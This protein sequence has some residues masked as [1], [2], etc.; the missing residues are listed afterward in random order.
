METFRLFE[1]GSFG[2]KLG[3]KPLG[4]VL[5]NDDTLHYLKACDINNL[6][7]LTAFS[8]LNEFIDDRGQRVKINYSSLDVEEFGSVYEG[9]LE[10][11]P[12]V[13]PGISESE[14]RFG[15][16]DGMDRKSTSSYYTRPDLVQH[17]IR[18]ALEPVI[19]A[20]IA[21]FATP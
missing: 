21:K 5:F 3:I 7:M 8:A 20:R 14:W 11:R 12:F 15:Y 16:V 18:S 10:M 17:L 2:E 9:I 4:G 13:Q 1:S 19:K 6:D